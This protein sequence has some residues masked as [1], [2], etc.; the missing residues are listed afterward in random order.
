[1]CACPS[2]Y[3]GSG[4]DITG[5]Y[6]FETIYYYNLTPHNLV[7]LT[8]QSLH[9]GYISTKMNNSQKMS[10]KYFGKRIQEQ[11]LLRLKFQWEQKDYLLLGFFFFLLAGASTDIRPQNSQRADGALRDVSQ[12]EAQ[13]GKAG[14][15]MQ[16]K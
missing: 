2:G 7:H 6:P 3:E 1:M 5:C 4:C 14:L 15:F 11:K 10:Q 8:E 13:S 9:L 16:Q 12:A